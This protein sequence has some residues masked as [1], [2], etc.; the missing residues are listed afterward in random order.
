MCHW[1]V[2][3]MVIISESPTSM[4]SVAF[5]ASSSTA[6]ATITPLSSSDTATDIC[7]TKKVLVPYS[8]QLIWKLCTHIWDW[9]HGLQSRGIKKSASL[10]K[11]SK[12][13]N[14]KMHAI[15]KTTRKICNTKMHAIRKTTRKIC[16]TKMH[17]RQH[18]ESAI[19][20]CMQFARQ[21]AKSAIPKCKTTRRICGNKV[22]ARQHAE[23]AIT[24]SMQDNKLQY[25]NVCKIKW[26][27][28]VFLILF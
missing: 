21:H 16:N 8:C 20:K 4:L 18:A 25:Q 13:C 2:T 11:T 15:R 26:Q 5:S 12:I 3:D 22:H 23:P 28:Q 19:P 14:T 24:E 6:P 1:P 17:A 7:H 27:V 10:Q 9:A